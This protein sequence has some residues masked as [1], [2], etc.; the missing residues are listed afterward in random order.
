MNPHYGILHRHDFS[1]EYD[2]WWKRRDRNYALPIPLTCL[3]LMMC[4]CACQH[5][6]VDYQ[7]RLERML[8]A[9]CQDRTE[10]Y[11]YH[12]RC[13]HG[14]APV[15]RYHRNNVLWLLHS[16]Y[17]YKAEAMFTECCH[18]FNTAVWEAQ[19]LGALH[20]G[21]SSSYANSLLTFW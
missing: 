3:L 21:R 8:N 14:V 6:P 1:R 15:G 16:V 7:A 20:Y 19:E 13:L 10:T 4:A 18:V 5:L 12:A 11:H 9:S 17:W 2:R